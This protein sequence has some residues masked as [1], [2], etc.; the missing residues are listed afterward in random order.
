MNQMR[1]HFRIGVRFE[2]V[3]ERPQ[4]LA[5]HLMIFDDAVMHERELVAREYRV[6]V[7]GHGRAVRRPAR[8]G[9]AHGARQSRVLY[10]LRKIRDAFG[11][12]HAARHA[13]LQD[14]NAT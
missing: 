1:N 10:L 8:V 6:R 3:A 5:Q 12:A 9:D 4:L 2:H 13:A 14:G 7:L 11:A